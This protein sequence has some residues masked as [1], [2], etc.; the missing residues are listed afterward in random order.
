MEKIEFKNNEDLV[1]FFKYLCRMFPKAM[2]YNYNEWR[3]KQNG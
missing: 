2:E 3:E 1:E